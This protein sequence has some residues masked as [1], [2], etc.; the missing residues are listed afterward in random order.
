M[1]ACSPALTS[2]VESGPA[3]V[4]P[5]APMVPPATTAPNTSTSWAPASSIEPPAPVVTIREVAWT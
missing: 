2:I 3:K 1:W 4:T 5:L